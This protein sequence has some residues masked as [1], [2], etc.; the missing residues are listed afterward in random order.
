MKAKIYLKQIQELDIKIE[1]KIAEVEYWKSVA[2]STTVSNDGERVQSSGSKQQMANAVCKYLQLEQELNNE[3]DMLV[4]TKQ[5]IINHIE[6]LPSNE[7]NVL[8]KMYVQG[9]EL[10]QMPERMNKSYSWVN[11]IHGRGISNLQKILDSE[12]N[13]KKC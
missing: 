11:A 13:D 9:Y 10:W 1:N 8:H 7:Y 2:S 4:A 6:Q 3:I 12:K 5:D